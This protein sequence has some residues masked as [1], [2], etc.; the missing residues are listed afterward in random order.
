MSN[1]PQ[2]KRQRT[3]ALETSNDSKKK[4]RRYNGQSASGQRP[5]L[6]D[7]TQM[8][9]VVRQF[10]LTILH[11]NMCCLR[12]GLG[13][14]SSKSVDAGANIII[15]TETKFDN[16]VANDAL[17]IQFSGFCLLS[18]RERTANGGGIAIWVKN[19]FISVQLK[20]MKTPKR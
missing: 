11:A 14:L 9:E 10:K 4:T 2:P 15:A 13:M 1:S 17:Q 19:S 7:Q 5:A 8:T 3:P 12:K 18:S 6:V 20:Q 16:T